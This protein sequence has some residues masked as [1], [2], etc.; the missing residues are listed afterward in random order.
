MKKSALHERDQDRPKKRRS[1]GKGEE[2]GERNGGGGG[3]RRRKNTEEDEVVMMRIYWM[4]SFQ[5]GNPNTRQNTSGA[6]VHS[7]KRRSRLSH[8][9]FAWL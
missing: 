5:G 8:S 6:V 9:L 7:P 2:E 1:E 4:D 3:E